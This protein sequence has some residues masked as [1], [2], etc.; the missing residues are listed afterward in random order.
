[1]KIAFTATAPD[2]SA[3]IDPRFGRA[4]YLMVYDEETDTLKTI[5]NNDIR[6]AEHGAGVAMAQKLFETGAQVLIT[7][8]GPGD[9][10]MKALNKM[11]LQIVTGM[12]DISLQKA[13][14]HYLEQNK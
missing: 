14:Q 6:Q 4:A 12:Y 5:D 1:M 8:N 9:S 10:A 11:S 2:W 7:G 3:L 13:Y